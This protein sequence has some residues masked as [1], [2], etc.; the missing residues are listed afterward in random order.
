MAVRG[1]FAKLSGL[2]SKLKRLTAPSLR[3]DLSK[4][5]GAEALAQVQLGFRGSRDPYGN[6]WASLALRSGKPLLDT[7]RLRNSFSAQVTATGFAIGTA[8]SYAA[9][10]QNGATILPKNGRFLKFRVGRRG[11]RW[12]QLKKAT[13]PRRQMVPQGELGA[14]W[15]DAFDKAATRFVSRILR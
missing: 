9:T 3:Q 5:V 10:H 2:T 1:D 11:G 4:V 12:Y 14:I 6:A 13:I 8:A 15:K 7:G